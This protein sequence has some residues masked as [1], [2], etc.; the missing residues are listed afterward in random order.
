[1]DADEPAAWSETGRYVVQ[2]L[3]QDA[4]AV[5]AA[6]VRLHR[7]GRYGL[8]SADQ[9]RDEGHLPYSENL[10]NLVVVKEFSVPAA[11]IF[12]VLTPGGEVMVRAGLLTTAELEGAGFKSVVAKAGEMT[13]RKPWPE[14]MDVWSHP[15]HDADGN[16]VSRDTEVGPPE[17][18][19]WVAAATQEVEGLVTAAGRSFYGGTLARD[20][21]NGL[22]LWHRDLGKTENNP[23]EFT[24][25][26]LAQ[27]RARPIASPQYLFAGSQ[28]KVVA[29]DA[30]SGAFVRDYAGVTEAKEILHVDDLIVATDEK[31]VHAFDAE[32]GE[33]VWHFPSAEVRHVVAGA[34]MV[35]F[36]RG[37]PRRGE[38]SE[39]VALTLKDGEV[40]PRRSFTKRL[41]DRYT[42]TTPW[43]LL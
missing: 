13:A 41:I 32:T 27:G 21:F 38:R 10:V 7:R 5:D 9:L 25:P 1:M 36:V 42:C 15:R 12:R 39:A 18:V 23:V 6:R 28:D 4:E 37:L 11:E 20:S 8:V 43:L 35:V 34:G 33:A 2:V 30:V 19:R 17:R 3:G 40:T 22:R 24:L 16:A 14:T 29:F 31:G 26:R